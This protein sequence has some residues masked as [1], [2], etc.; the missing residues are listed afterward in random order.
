MPANDA[1]LNILSRRV[2]NAGYMVIGHN[3]NITLDIFYY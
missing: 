2:K 3:E 1:Q